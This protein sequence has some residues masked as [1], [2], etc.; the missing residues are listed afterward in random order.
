M[1]LAATQSTASRCSATRSRIRLSPA[2]VLSFVAIIRTGRGVSGGEGGTAAA[3]GL[4]VRVADDELRTAEVLGVVDLGAGE[5][6]QRERID[7]QGDAFT[8]ERE[9]VFRL[10]FVESEP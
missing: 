1:A 5:V 10:R 4:G 8:G 6:L 7:Q 2:N 9:I 3:G